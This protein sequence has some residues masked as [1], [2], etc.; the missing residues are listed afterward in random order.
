[1]HKMHNAEEFLCRFQGACERKQFG[2]GFAR[3]FNRGDHE[4]RVHHIFQENPRSKGRPKGTSIISEASNA[5]SALR[6]NSVQGKLSL[7][8]SNNAS[9]ESSTK[10]IEQHNHLL[11]DSLTTQ[12]SASTGMSFPL[13]TF[14]ST[15]NTQTAKTTS[16]M[17][18][19]APSTTPKS[20]RLDP[21]PRSITPPL[22]L[23]SW[24]GS[25]T[26][27][28][29]GPSTRHS[30][31]VR[32]PTP[33]MLDFSSTTPTRVSKAGVRSTSTY[34][35]TQASKKR[36]LDQWAEHTNRLGDLALLLPEVRDESSNNIV[37][38]IEQEVRELLA[39]HSDIDFRPMENPK[40]IVEHGNELRDR[41]LR[42]P[43]TPFGS[44]TSNQFSGSAKARICCSFERISNDI[45]TSFVAGPV[46]DPSGST[47]NAAALNSSL[48]EKTCT[49]ELT[50]SQPRQMILLTDFQYAMQ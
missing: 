40:S 19:T 16:S 13:M 27:S 6:R 22:V 31:V 5:H 32:N 11:D 9:Y 21:Y 25:W 41:S 18:D 15:S 44:Q 50:I 29:E 7:R 38:S 46:G 3:S 8:N 33:V 14:G 24:T 20:T 1:M 23:H 45:G 2:N 17:G 48:A 43:T 34:G 28:F 12:P 35:F 49:G 26:S 4:K 10:L 42:L 37:R 39:I 36:R 47:A 30:P